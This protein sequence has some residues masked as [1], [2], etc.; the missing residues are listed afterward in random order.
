M[1]INNHYEN[2]INILNNKNNF[3][4]YNKND[5]SQK[6]E[7]NTTDIN[8]GNYNTI[9]TY[10]KNIINT[11]YTVVSDNNDT[12][13]NNK[14]YDSI[15]DLEID[16]LEN[17]I[18][19]E[20]NNYN[21]SFKIFNDNIEKLNKPFFEFNNKFLYEFKDDYTQIEFKK[22]KKI[23]DLKN[24]F[25]KQFNSKKYMNNNC[26]VDYIIQIINDELEKIE[27][28]NKNMMINTDLNYN[29]GNG[30]GVSVDI[31]KI[32]FQ[33]FLEKTLKI[34][35]HYK[36]IYI[37]QIDIDDLNTK[38]R[39]IIDNYNNAKIEIDAADVAINAD[40]TININ[41]L[42]AYVNSIK[43]N[44]LIL[45]LI[46]AYEH[47]HPNMGAA[48]VG[49][50][51]TMDKMTSEINYIIRNTV[52]PVDTNDH[53]SI[54]TA[55]IDAINTITVVPGYVLQIVG[56]GV[57]VNDIES[58][59]N[60]IFNNI[61]NINVQLNAAQPLANNDRLI[62][63]VINAINTLVNDFNI[64]ANIA[65]NI[66]AVNTSKNILEANTQAYK[67]AFDQITTTRSTNITEQIKNLVGFINNNDPVKNAA[68]AVIT[69]DAN[70]AKKNAAHVPIEYDH[71]PLNSLTFDDNIKP[72]ITDHINTNL[73]NAVV[74]ANNNLLGNLL[75]GVGQKNGS[76][77]FII[78][79]SIFKISE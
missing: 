25:I 6:L 60:E 78:I 2:I 12:S 62:T 29:Y 46:R 10:N 14:I 76:N 9:Y 53:A 52:P 54:T 33:T 69:N 45:A 55:I 68:S 1:I 38:L 22:T 15:F 35:D 8:T 16:I 36:T 51:D 73:K 44:P 75:D 19:N 79:Y 18:D 47:L 49:N 24:D 71:N 37:N 27:D 77:H 39:T 74:N 3:N 61:N 32:F 5:T 57:L 66:A 17:K 31:F 56:G 23:A 64:P 70:N 30:G 11:F 65:A 20:I 48:I 63:D 40:K 7:F 34:D 72:K 50:V 21:N 58:A 41:G 13:E 28:D 43:M 4:M 26:N 59:I 67:T 42:N